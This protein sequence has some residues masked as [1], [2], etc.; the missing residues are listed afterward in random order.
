MIGNERLRADYKALTP[1]ETS[2]K[3]TIM[4]YAGLGWPRPK[5]DIRI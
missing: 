3:E 2:I 5:T 1:F 4:Y